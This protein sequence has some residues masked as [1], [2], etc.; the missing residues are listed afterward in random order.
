MR[1]SITY[2]LLLIITSVLS[3]ILRGYVFKVLWGWFLVPTVMSFTPS[4]VLC[5]GIMTIFLLLTGHSISRKETGMKSSVQVTLWPS[6]DVD[7]L[8]VSQKV[9]EEIKALRTLAD[10]NLTYSIGETIQSQITIPL[11]AL[12]MGWVLKYFL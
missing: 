10:R 2:L 12:A 3:V 1:R 4:L 9:K 7:A 11:T 8:S 6:F 5:M